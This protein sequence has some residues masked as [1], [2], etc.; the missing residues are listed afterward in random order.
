M[1]RIVHVSLFVLAS[2][3]GVVLGT[4][5]RDSSDELQ[6]HARH[7]APAAE[8]EELEA[9]ASEVARLRGMMAERD[10]QSQGDAAEAHEEQ[11]LAVLIAREREISERRASLLLAVAEREAVDLDWA[12]AMEQQIAS[13][14]AIHG[15]AGAKLL[16]ASCKRTICVAEIEHARGSDGDGPLDWRAI[17]SS[18]R[19]FVVHHDPTPDRA[20]RTIAY[21]ARDGHSLPR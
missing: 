12:P 3:A 9:L 1:N 2:G 15:P 21:L 18:S 7:P 6:D 20:A 11:D 4:L 5:I 19:G 10:Q 13:G 17:L 8:R 14:F 16:S